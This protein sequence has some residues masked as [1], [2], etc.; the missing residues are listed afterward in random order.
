MAIITTYVFK[1]IGDIF[2]GD[3]TRATSVSS[4]G[5][6][7]FITGYKINGDGSATN[8]LYDGTT[9]VDLG[10]FVPYDVNRM[11]YIAGLY[12]A[13]GGFTVPYD[14]AIRV[15]ATEQVY[16][17]PSESWVNGDAFASAIN[18]SGLAVGCMAADT[19]SEGLHYVAVW[20]IFS[21]EELTTFSMYAGDDPDINANGDIIATS[22]ATTP[23]G[24]AAWAP[25]GHYGNWTYL[26]GQTDA[27]T[28]YSKGISINDS[29]IMLVNGYR[30]ASDG[31]GAFLID[32]DGNETAITNPLDDGDYFFGTGLNNRGDI[33]GWKGT[34]STKRQGFVRYANGDVI[35]LPLLSY[36]LHID[37]GG[38][39]VGYYYAGSVTRAFLFYSHDDDPEKSIAGGYVMPVDGA[40]S[41]ALAGAPSTK[42]WPTPYQITSSQDDVLYAIVRRTV[43]G[44]T[45]RYIER[46]HC[47]Y[48][49]D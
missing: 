5:D 18:E 13:E 15:Y 45:V 20:D 38:R 26:K 12:Q 34:A 49:G 41:F 3:D 23:N 25:A 9:A 30:D 31:L 2:G 35:L 24:T 29:R 4:T 1:D 8:T 6:V 28:D 22:Y 7:L 21:G 11:G 19:P 37:D 32:E 46:K 36:P 14:A 33:V 27:S 44:Q 10:G 48:F 17:W 47:R 43:N 39:V 16:Q 42:H 40:A